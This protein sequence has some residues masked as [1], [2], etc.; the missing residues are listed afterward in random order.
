MRYVHAF[1]TTDAHGLQHDPGHGADDDLHEA[2]VIEHRKEAEMKMMVGSTWN[3]KM[4]AD[5]GAITLPN[6]PPLGS[7]SWPNRT[8]VPAKVAESMLLTTP[9]AQVMLAGRSQSAAPGM[10][11]SPASRA[12]GHCAPAYAFAISRAE[13]RGN[14][15]GQNP[16]NPVN[17][18]KVPP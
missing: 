12:P 15:H 8:A 18:S 6:A 14:Q 2:D 3:A 4:D 7:P 1:R 16:S 5:V 11:R 9:P 17:R 13:P 10:R